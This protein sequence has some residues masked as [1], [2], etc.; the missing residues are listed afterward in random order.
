MPIVS[1]TKRRRSAESGQ[2]TLLVILIIGILLLGFVALAV[3][4]SHL[5]FKRQ[6]AQGAADAACQAAAMNMLVAATGSATPTQGFTVGTNFNCSSTPAASPCKYAAL[7]GYNAGGLVSNTES[8]EVLVSF[9]G[10]VPGVTPPS[11]TLAPTP[12]VRVDVIDR[13]RVFFAPLFTGNKTQDVRA[14]AVCGLVQ[15]AAPIP[16][17]VLNPTCNHAFEVSGS[18]TLKIVGGPGRSVQVNSIGN[19]PSASHCA[20]A[21]QSSAGQCSGSGTIDLSQGGPSFSGSDFGTF[22]GPDA[23]PTG[24]MPGATGTWSSPSS[25]IPDPFATVP[26]PTRPTTLGT[27]QLVDFGEWGCPDHT[28]QCRLYSPGLYT[29]P[30]QVDNETAIFKAGVYFIEPTSYPGGS[31]GGTLCG[32]PSTNCTTN[33]SGQCRAALVVGN[34]GVVRPAAESLTGTNLT[35]GAIFY[36]SGSTA[37]GYGSAVF[38]SNAGNYGG[39]IVDQFP[40][41]QMTCPGGTAPSGL[42]GLPA[43][44]DGNV[45]LGECT[46]G[47]TYIAHSGAGAARGLIMFQDRSNGDPHGQMNMQGGGGLLIS[48]TLYAHHC[49]ASPC[50]ATDYKAFLQLQGSPGSGT[51]VFGEI[52]ADQ[53]VLS[54]NGT[55]KMQLSPD[56]ILQILKVQLLR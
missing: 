54:G 39:R 31:S 43:S 32:S 56:A 26:A 40:T 38:T 13:A 5:W 41:S 18:A 22:G 12:F 46:A 51:Y 6:T 15:A 14:G 3:D 24:Y 9:P 33:P 25:P 19:T 45:L 2:S 30:I 42:I 7:N 44:V 10:S 55:V 48:G 11:S 50:P 29:Q 52:V 1:R 35:G 37:N 49:T 36:L 21:T 20:A 4:Y 17:I 47:G 28:K 23:A 16:L 34:N 53:F 8:R 27:T